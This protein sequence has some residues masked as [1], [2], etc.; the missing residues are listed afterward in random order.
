MRAGIGGNS[1]PG[2]AFACQMLRNKTTP[3]TKPTRL[4]LATFNVNNVNRR[5]PN[6]IAWLRTRRPDIVC[7][8]ELKAAQHAFPVAALSAGGYG[9]LER[10]EDL[11]RRSHSGARDRTR[12]DPRCAARRPGRRTEPLHAIATIP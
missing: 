5:L 9:G 6:L 1:R 3:K 11:E 12:F 8:Q 2:A 10:P 4:T 7:L